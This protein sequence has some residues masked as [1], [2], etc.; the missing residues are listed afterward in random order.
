MLNYMLDCPGAVFSAFLLLE[1]ERIRGCFLLSRL[2]GQTRIAEVRLD[3]E[4]PVDWEAAYALATRSAAQDPHTCEILAVTSIEAGRMALS[5]NRY[6]LRRRDP[7]F[8]YDPKQ[9]LSTLELNVNML[10]GDEAYLCDPAY[11]YET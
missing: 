2:G 8:V 9:L 1:G 10:E 5:R 3:S 11:P 4:D 7:I 6:R